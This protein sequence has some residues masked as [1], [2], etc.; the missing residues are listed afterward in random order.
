MKLATWYEQQGH[1]VTY[2]DLSTHQ[3]DYTFASKVFVA[4]S[5]YDLQAKLPPEIEEVKPDYEKFGINY[6]F[7]FTSR[8]CVRGCDFCIVQ[9]KEGLFHDVS[10]EWAKGEKRVLLLDNNFF[11]SPIWKEKLQYFIDNKVKVCFNQGLDIRLI[12]DEKAEMLSK[13]LYYDDQFKTRRLYF[14]FDDLSIEP[15]LEEKIKILEKYGIK[16][17]RLMFYFIVN[18][19]TTFEQSMHQFEVLDKLGCMPYPM[20]YDKANAPTRIKDFCRWIIK[21]YYK[22]VTFEQYEAKVRKKKPC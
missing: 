4:G 19:H 11:L 20:L 6:S 15:I 22:L 12:N 2:I 5:G 17:S 3:F 8:G 13:V 7:G 16:P 21:R 1:E 10:Y 18:H 9:P 14:A